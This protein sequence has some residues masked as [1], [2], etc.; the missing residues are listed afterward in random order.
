M[1]CLLALLTGSLLVSC[2]KEEPSVKD[3]QSVARKEAEDATNIRIENATG[4]TFES[5]EVNTPDGKIPM[6]LSLPG[7]NQHT[8]LL[9]LLTAMPM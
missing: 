4:F 1:F 9:I 7:K 8:R 3:D 6:A 5:V 2:T